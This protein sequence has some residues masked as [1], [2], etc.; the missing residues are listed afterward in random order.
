MD[1][2]KISLASPGISGAQILGSA[3][4]FIFYLLF[5][6]CQ[7]QLLFLMKDVS[8]TKCKDMMIAY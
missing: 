5:L 3:F 8:K 2:S 6:C 4:L 1:R 7:G